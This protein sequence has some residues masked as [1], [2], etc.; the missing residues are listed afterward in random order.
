MRTRI[1]FYFL[2]T[3]VLV[4]ALHAQTDWPTYGHDKGGMRYSPLTQINP[5][6]VA[7]LTPVWTFHM[8]PQGQKFL[9]G[10][11][12]PLVANGVMY[13]G[14]PYNRIVALEPETGN[15]IWEYT[16]AR[17]VGPKRSIEYWPG[18]KDNPPEILSD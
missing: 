7:K 12:V 18:D 14:T 2:L 16:E 13:I 5:Q 9:N 15:L 6:N 17:G 11:T 1:I 8:A 4:P 3:A 10:E